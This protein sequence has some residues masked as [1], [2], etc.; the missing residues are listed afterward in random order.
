MALIGYARVSTDEQTTD[1]QIDA[2][3]S[4]GC[5]TIH[6]EHASGGDRTRPELRRAIERCRKGDVL[7]VVRIDRLARSLAHLLEIIEALDLKGAGFRSLGDPIDTTSPQ[8]RFTL[9]ILGAVAEFER[10]L[11]RERTKAGLKAAKE[12]G[13]IGGNPGLRFRSATA[14]RAVHSAREARRDADV[15]RVADGIL[16]HVRAMR[17]AYPWEIVA[18]SLDRSGSRR[19]DGGS[20]TGPALARAVRRLARDG[21]VDKAVLERTP[22]RRDTDDLVTLVA[23]AVKTLESPTL[24]NIARHL[25]GLHCRTPRGETRWAVSSVQNLLNQAVA[26]GLLEDRP[27]PAPTAP[28]RR[29]RPPKSL[30]P[31]STNQ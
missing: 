28:R 19:P 21:F 17:P 8:G 20:W 24:T 10:A 4:A 27:L 25:E 16:P 12:R 31:A 3:K 7:V 23:M 13:R 6:R 1:P 26:Q 22:R 9:Q 29:G 30:K 15:L 2:L 14:L 18:R 11:I 5:A